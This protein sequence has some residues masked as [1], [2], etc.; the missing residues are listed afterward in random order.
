MKKSVKRSGNYHKRQKHSERKV[1]TSTPISSA[2]S[3][4]TDMLTRAVQYHESG[5]FIEAEK[6]YSKILNDAP[7]HPDALHL[8]GLVAAQAGRLA[9][10][11]ELIRK[12][13][14]VRPDFGDG[15]DNMGRV[16]VALN[17]RE[18]AA[19]HF[20]KAVELNSGKAPAYVNLGYTLYEL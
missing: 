8:L 2:T 18:D 3:G 12:S 19:S 16:L 1:D 15:H 9:D 13:L 10:A 6:I 14:D 4:A 17:R 7:N 11:E 20:K 5:N